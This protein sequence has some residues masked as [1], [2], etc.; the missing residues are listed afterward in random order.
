MHFVLD[1]EL[2][3]FQ[4]DSDD[5]WFKRLA[6]SVAFQNTLYRPR[7]R[8]SQPISNTNGILNGILNGRWSAQTPRPRLA[9]SCS[10]ARDQRAACS[11][12]QSGSVCLERSAGLFLGGKTYFSRQVSFDNDDAS[13]RR[14]RRRRQVRSSL[15][16]S[17]FY[18]ASHG[19]RGA[20]TAAS[21][22]ELRALRRESRGLALTR[23][24][25]TPATASIRVSILTRI[26][27]VSSPIWT[28][29]SVLKCHRTRA[30]RFSYRS[31][32]PRKSSRPSLKF[33]GIPNRYCRWTL[34]SAA[35]RLAPSPAHARARTR[36]ATRPKRPE[37][38]QEAR[39]AKR[40]ARD[41]FS[42]DM[43]RAI[44]S[45]ARAALLEPDATQ[46]KAHR[47]V[48]R[49]ECPTYAYNA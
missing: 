45:R 44:R 39:A 10:A 5:Q 1:S 36:T 20:R 2:S 31:S 19:E 12:V 46:R 41:P 34:P 43:E 42:L 4:S 49:V 32:S 38:L 24:A 3:R 18:K 15:S 17:L 29:E 7:P 11:L 35:P 40:L 23:P 16:L 25:P 37:N 9:E 13:A 30:R 27:V 14:R 48:Q 26:S 8:P 47:S 33:N 21:S 22:R 28:M 6:R